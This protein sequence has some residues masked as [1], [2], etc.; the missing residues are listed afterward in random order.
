MK[1]LKAVDFED[2]KQHERKY[3]EIM[4]QQKYQRESRV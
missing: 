3:D 2:I 4:R 1:K